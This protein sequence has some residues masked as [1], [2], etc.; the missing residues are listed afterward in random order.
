[1]QPRL[2]GYGSVRPTWYPHQVFPSRWTA[3]R[4]FWRPLW[5]P[6]YAAS[7][8]VAPS[9]PSTPVT[10]A[11][12]YP[13]AQPSYPAVQPVETPCD[14]KQSQETYVQPTQPV[15]YVP[16]PMPVMSAAQP[17]PDCENGPNMTAQPQYR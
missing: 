12:S 13:Q 2:G 6:T 7:Y 14:E 10:Y 3:A 1:L 5:R 16:A 17:T 11:P 4:P 9:Y 8:P 15:S